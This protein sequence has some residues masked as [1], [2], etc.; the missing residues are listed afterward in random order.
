MQDKCQSA[1]NYIKCLN[2]GGINDLTV[3]VNARAIDEVKNVLKP[4]I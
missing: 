3:L 4:K 2:A 1:L